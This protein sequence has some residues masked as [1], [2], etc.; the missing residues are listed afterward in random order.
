MK[1]CKDYQ[2]ALSAYTGDELSGNE[3]QA[4]TN[5]LLHCADC[6]D[7]LEREEE[8]RQHLAGLPQVNCP[9]HVFEA[10]MA[11]TDRPTTK[12]RLRNRWP[13]AGIAVAATLA[14]LFL[15]GFNGVLTNDVPHDQMAVNQEFSEAEIAQAKRDVMA[16]LTLAANVVSRSRQDTMSDIFG[17]RL[18]NALSG[19]LSPSKSPRKGTQRTDAQS[20]K[21]ET[22]PHTAHSGGNG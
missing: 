8:L 6:R 22:D 15:P 1:E 4:L 18:P 5:H 19:S 9:G 12:R 11:Q 21:F 7:E 20:D 3:R 16:T 13:W 14:V 10:I 2:A 17:T